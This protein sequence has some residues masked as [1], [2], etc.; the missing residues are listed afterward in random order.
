MSTEADVKTTDSDTKDGLLT[1]DDNYDDIPNENAC[2]I[3]SSKPTTRDDYVQT[4]SKQDTRKTTMSLSSVIELAVKAQK[5]DKAQSTLAYSP[6]YKEV[7]VIVGKG[8]GETRRIPVFQRAKSQDSD[9]QA[10]AS[11]AS[12]PSANTNKWS[13]VRRLI[14]QEATDKSSPSY[15]KWSRLRR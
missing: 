1:T 10:I 12:Q 14:S 5:E 4:P 11:P 13:R 2:E 7:S 15:Q 6:E 3:A 8:E 9:T